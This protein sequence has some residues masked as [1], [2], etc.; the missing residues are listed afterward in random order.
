[1][2]GF[3]QLTADAISGEAKAEIFRRPSPTA[4]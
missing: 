1:M 2:P 3:W 4:N